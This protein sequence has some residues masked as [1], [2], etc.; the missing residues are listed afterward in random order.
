MYPS[1]TQEKHR[2]FG[3]KHFCIIIHAARDL[4]AFLAKT[5]P[6]ATAIDTAFLIWLLKNVFRGIFRKM[7]LCNQ[8]LWHFKKTHLT[9]CLL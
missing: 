1:D 8:K 3:P 5:P 9:K 7:P 4:K 2:T 6:I